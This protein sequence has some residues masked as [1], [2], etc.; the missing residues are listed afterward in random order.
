MDV[1][2]G[3]FSKQLCRTLSTLYNQT[4][5]ESLR[6]LLVSAVKLNPYLGSTTCVMA[7]IEEGGRLKT[8]NLGDSGYLLLRF[9]NH[10]IVTVHHSAV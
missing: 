6:Q 3:M 8:C 2:P 4:P 10:G 9:D 1:D 5:T 7:S